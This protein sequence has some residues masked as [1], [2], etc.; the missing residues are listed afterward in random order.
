MD[1]VLAGETFHLPV[2]MLMEAPDQI[3]SD[4]DMDCPIFATGE[5]VDA[6]LLQTL[7][8]HLELVSGSIFVKGSAVSRMDAETSSA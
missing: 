4:A 7:P 3:G 6:R 1:F 2:A 8:R 5:N